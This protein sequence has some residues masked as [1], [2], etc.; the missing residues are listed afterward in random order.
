MDTIRVEARQLGRKKPLLSDWSVALPST[1]GETPVT[2]APAIT[3]RELITTVV[4]AEVEA[5]HDRQSQYQL[6][7]VL[8]KAAIATGLNQG[9]VTMGDGLRPTEGQRE[10]KQAVDPQAAV[11]TAIL[12][13]VDGLY[14]VFVDDIQQEELDRP[15][16]LRADS[17]LMFLRLVPLVGG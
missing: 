3:L 11:D 7:Q 12:G 9:K 8:S 16:P 1:G 15:V 10:F 17:R 6:T 4:L 2:V 14:Y 5:F 13:F